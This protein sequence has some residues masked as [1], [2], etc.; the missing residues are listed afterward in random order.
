MIGKIMP[1]KDI[2]EELVAEAEAA[3]AGLNRFLTGG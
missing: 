2:M 3:I 1:V